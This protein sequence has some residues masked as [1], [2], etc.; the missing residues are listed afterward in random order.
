[1]FLQCSAHFKQ[2]SEQY[3]PAF[4]QRQFLLHLQE[5]IFSTASGAGG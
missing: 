4:L 3:S 5:I 1:M 2:R